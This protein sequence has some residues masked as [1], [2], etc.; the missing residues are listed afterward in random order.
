MGRLIAHRLLATIPV[1]LLVT[2]G[3]FA[4]LHLT[5]GDPIDAMMAESVDATA[6]D[7]LR[8]ELGLDRPIPVQYAAWMGRLLRGDLGRSIRNGEPVIENV[9]RRIRPSLELALLAMAISLTIAFPVAIASAVRHNTGVDRLGTTFALFCI[10]MPNF[11]LALLLLFLFGVTLRWLPISGYVDPLEEGWDG[12][13]SLVLPAVTL[14]LALAAVVTR[15][16]RSSLLDALAEDYVRTARAKGLSEGAVIRGHVLKNA[17]I[18][19][20]TVLGLQLGTLIGG[21]VIT[22]YVFALPGVGRLVVDAVFARDYPLVQGVVLLIAIGFILSN[23]VD[24]L[25]GWIDPR[26]RFR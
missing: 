25:Y 15:T 16:L 26:I 12:V 17:L 3:V 2:A 14:G 11:L 4:L 18:P 9:S 10:C 8:R 22:E 13:R 1:L 21:A 5:P 23:L 7:A 20:V 6:K 24:V 19:V